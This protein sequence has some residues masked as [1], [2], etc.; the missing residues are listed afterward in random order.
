MRA[1]ARSDRAPALSFEIT[2]DQ[3]ALVYR[4]VASV[5]IALRELDIE[6]LF[7]R[8]P[9]WQGDTDRFSWVAPAHTLRCDLPPTGTHAVP[10][11]EGFRGRNVVVEVASGA[12][13]RAQPH[14]AHDLAVVVAEPEGAIEVGRRGGA[15]HRGA[16]VKVYARDLDG[17]VSF[18]K[19]GYTDIRGRFDYASLTAAS[20]QRVA[21]FALL[22]A[23][24]DAGALVLEA[25]PPA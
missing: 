14:Y 20:L 8:Q 22:V 1:G 4:N 19:D 6:L 12:I 7:S 13:R 21:R 23:S 10:I 9:F 18:Y 3:I 17:R 2:G 25:A 5:A 11:P 16:Y 15:R 24:D